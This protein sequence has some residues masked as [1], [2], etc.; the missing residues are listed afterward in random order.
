GESGPPPLSEAARAAVLAAPGV[1]RERLARAIDGLFDN[2]AVG[3][4]RAVLV[5]SGGRVVAE[6]YGSGYGPDTRL[7]GWSMSKSITGVLIGLLVSDGR[8]RLDESVPIPAWQRSGD[9]RGEITLRQLL[10]MRAGLR[11]TEGGEP[12]WRSDEVRMLFLDGRD[13][14]AAYAEAQP[15][16]AEPGSRFEYSSATSVI[17]AD[18]AARALTE[19]PDPE[20]RRRAV[21]EYLRT[22]LFEPAGMRSMLPEFDAAGTLIGS[23]MIHGTARDWA[24]FGEFLR[25]GG[26]VRGAQVLPHG[27]IEFMTRPSP[28]NP[29]YGAQLWLN[30]PQPDGS[31][32]LLP[33]RA[34]AD[35]FACVGH[36]GQYVLVS[37][38]QRLTVV[39]LGASDATQRPRV[40][41]QLAAIVALFPKR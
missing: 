26:A 9:A 1:P 6:R 4:T 40:L 30:R 37:P 12:L 2:A 18:L 35:L 27:W 7:I 17:L 24:R 22:R 21:A 20:F 39:R 36:L 5:L 14:M 34:P 13:D 28:R 33:G 32:V 29:G 11:H 38:R 8:L 19:S 3:E 10:Q 41:D 25:N 31:V 15:L 23:S 16:E